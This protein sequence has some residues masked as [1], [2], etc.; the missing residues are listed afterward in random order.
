MPRAKATE[1]FE[2]RASQTRKARYE[3]AAQ[4]RGMSLSE[5]ARRTLDDAAEVELAAGGPAVPSDA[6]VAD[7]LRAKGAAARLQAARPAG[8][9]EGDPVELAIL[10]A[11]VLADY[12]L[13]EGAAGAVAARLEAKAAATTSVVVHEVARGIEPGER[14]ALL[15]ALRGVRVYP[16]DARAARRAVDIWRELESTGRRVG[17]RDVLTAAIA[18]EAKLPVLTRNAAHFGRVRGLKLAR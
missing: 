14:A 15:R 5:W 17:D 6:D 13:G 9:A 11:D 1:R 12:L 2:V 18:M 16:L 3:S 8:R 4:R 7:A 10:D